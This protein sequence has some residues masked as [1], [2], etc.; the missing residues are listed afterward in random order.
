MI[1]EWST[2]W[3]GTKT[4]KSKAKAK[5]LQLKPGDGWIRRCA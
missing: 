1:R 2:G 5:K 3:L 4:S